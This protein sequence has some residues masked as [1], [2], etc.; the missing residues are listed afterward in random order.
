M[1]ASEAK[2]L[3]G[4]TKENRNA[5]RRK[6]PTRV[7]VVCGKEF[8]RNNTRKITCSPECHRRDI[9]DKWNAWA[10][11]KRTKA[12]QEKQEQ[13]IIN[14]CPVCGKDKGKNKLTCSQKCSTEYK[15]NKK[16][17]VI[18]GAEYR[19]PPTDYVKTCSAACRKALRQKVFAERKGDYMEAFEKGLEASRASPL[20]Q[21]DENNIKAK[22]WVLQSPDGKIYACRNLLN[23]IRENAEMF[24]GTIRQAWD[25]ITKIKYGLQGKRKSRSSQ[26]KGWRLLEWGD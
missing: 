11:A 19:C 1:P 20:H 12:K 26:W 10:K 3:H 17:C 6:P 5:K 24:D 18:C 25:G 21:R 4:K 22:E 23:F 7:C 16:I 9:K 8:E 2:G 13:K 15:S 14:P